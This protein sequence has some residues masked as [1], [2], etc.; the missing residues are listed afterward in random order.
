MAS[1]MPSPSPKGGPDGEGAL[2]DPK[3]KLEV[4]TAVQ[5]AG[6]LMIGDD[7]AGAVEALESALRQE[8]GMPQA[9]LMLGATYAALDRRTDAIAQFDQVR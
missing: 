8:P 4:F 9:L 1:Q 3:D 5:R 2:A 7:H 6:E